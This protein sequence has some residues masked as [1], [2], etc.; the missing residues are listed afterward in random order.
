MN[1]FSQRHIGP[2]VAEKNAMLSKIGVNSINELID[3]TIPAHIR[4]NGELAITKAMS[5]QEY[6][7]HI[8][9]LGQKNQAFKSFIGLG[10]NETIVPSVILRNILENPGWYT[11]YTPYQAEISQGR[12]EALLNF[13]TMVSDLTGLPLSNASLLDEGTAAAE[14]MIMFLNSRSRADVKAGKLKFFISEKAFPQTIDVVQ[15]KAENLGIKLTIGNPDTFTPTEEYF[16]SIIQYPNMNG[17]VANIESFISRMN[18]AGVR[19]AVGADILSLVLLK[20]PGSL[21]ADVVF[22]T[23]QRF[24]VPMG[25][26]GPHAAFFSA[27]NAFGLE[28][29]TFLPNRTWR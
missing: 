11:A 6:L 12:L 15:G 24:G 20:S 16:G 18:E 2:N 7:T 22:G 5:E 27:K 10:Y 25:Y 1:K 13:Q 9:E 14:A 28:N 4:L 29:F 8:T 19:V 26:G 3:Q 23:S 17:A 21:G